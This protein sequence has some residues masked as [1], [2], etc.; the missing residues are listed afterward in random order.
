[1]SRLVLGS[2]ASLVLYRALVGRGD[3]RRALLPS[4]VCAALPM[5]FVAAGIEVEFVDIDPATLEVDLAICAERIA[6]EA[7]GHYGA[8]V[9]VR[10]YGALRDL[11]PEL[12]ALRALQPD[13]ML[14]DDRC[15]CDPATARED[16]LG[17]VDL[18]LFSTGRRKFA[19]LGYGGFGIL[20]SDIPYEERCS[21]PWR[22]GD[23]ARM[24]AHVKEA[25][26]SGHAISSETL[27]GLDWI[28]DTPRVEESDD[29][30]AEVDAAAE[31]ARSVRQRHDAIYRAV[32]PSEAWL[33]PALST[34][35]F[36]VVLNESSRAVEGL[37]ADGLFASRHYPDLAPAFGQP[38]NPAAA[39][40][41]AHVVNLFSDHHVDEHQV[42]RTARH[43]ADHVRRTGV[44]DVEL[45][46]YEAR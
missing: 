12:T 43:V 36:N 45:P 18:R 28:D 14:I 17:P 46:T 3:H 7:P 9:V 37:F 44:P 30:L 26:R 24:E 15:L 39:Q 41:A 1:M 29:Y 5:T 10:P 20:S 19:D 32:I 6:E 23:D 34:W 25:L 2:R 8:V 21:P 40:L 33:G 35:R 4:N 22:P 16:P 38:E 11:T 42:S 13:L 31:R 27:E